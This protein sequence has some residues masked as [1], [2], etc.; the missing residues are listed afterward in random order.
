M[1]TQL[2]HNG[3]TLD[4]RTRRATVGER[5]VDLSAREFA[6]AET[7]LRNAGQVLSR[8]QLLDLTQKHDAI[9]FDRSIDSQI[10]RLRK[11]LEPDS[12]HP[13]LIKTVR[14]DGYVL[15][16]SIKRARG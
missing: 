4:L 3:L 1:P 11:K 10:S 14:G 15:A 7:F 8:E 2:T 5:S 16:T 6:L 12:R 13:R 9:T